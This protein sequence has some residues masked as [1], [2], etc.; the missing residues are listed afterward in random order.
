MLEVYLSLNNNNLR[1]TYIDKEGLKTYSAVIPEDIVS[2]TKILDVARYAEEIKKGL[3]QVTKYSPA[4]LFLN[5]I[6]EPEDVILRFITVNKRDGDK[7]EQLLKDMKEKITE[8]PLEDLY[9]SYQKIAPFLYQFVGVRKEY[10]ETLLEVSNVVGISL[11]S[12]VPWLLLLPKYLGINDP[13]VFICRVDGSHAMALSEL[14]G[15]FY[16]GVSDKLITA[17]QLEN[18][19]SDLSFYKK[20]TPVRNIYTLNYQDFDVK[21]FEVSE[22]GMPPVQTEYPEEFKINMLVNYMLD[23]DPD[24]V[25]NQMNLL[26]LMPLPVVEKKTSSLVYV[27]VASLFLIMGV[28]SFSL[29]FRK[30]GGS[31]NQPITDSGQA[32]VLS[33]QVSQNENPPVEQKVELKKEDLKVM[34]LNGSGVNGLA[35]RTKTLLE[36]K[37]YKVVDIDTADATR[38]DTL[39]KFK[40]DRI[41][42]N[43]IIQEDIKEAFPKVAVEDT[44]ADSEEYDLLIIAGTTSEL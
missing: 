2:D 24:L 28:L 7:Q 27:G 35:A 29:I 10:M 12:V 26:N 21:G 39:L 38:E 41:A 11:K 22:I 5:V 37:G 25:A 14:G 44:L 16:S 36:E 32:N 20:K 6:S 19:V 40:K 30:G 15:I 34:I 1:L 31:N 43:D 42:F 3:S 18:F 9:F 17:S 8:V 33:E 13:A 4:K 23:N